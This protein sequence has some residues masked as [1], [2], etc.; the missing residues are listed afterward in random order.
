MALAK[1]SFDE[2][3]RLVGYKVSEPFKKY[4]APMRISEKQKRNRVAL[5]EKLED[6]MISMLA[7]MFYAD[8]YGSSSYDDAYEKAVAEYLMAIQM[9][10]GEPDDYLISH[11]KETIANTLSVLFKHRDDPYYYS[12]DRARAIAEDQANQIYAYTEYEEILDDPSIRYK[13]WNTII[14]GRERDS[15]HEANGLTIPILE[16]FELRGGYLQFPGDGS[17]GC[18]EEELVRCRCSLSFS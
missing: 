1:M 8:Q 5:A 9:L 4:F 17:L 2:L 3:N 16:P 11:A 6:A 13:T 18:S 7:E 15:H 14:D 12:N 10:I